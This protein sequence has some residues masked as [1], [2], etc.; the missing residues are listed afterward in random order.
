MRNREAVAFALAPHAGKVLTQDIARDIIATLFPD[1]HLPIER[2]EPGHGGKCVIRGELLRP[3]TEMDCLHDAYQQETDGAMELHYDYDR[4]LEIQHDGGFAQFTARIAET[5]EL[6]GVMRVFVGKNERTGHIFC[7]DN[8][9]FI[10]P[11]H[12]GIELSTRLWRYAERCMFD[13]GVRE[14]TFLSR[15]VNGADRMAKFLGYVPS[16]VQFSKVHV[17]DDYAAVTSRHT[18][19]AKP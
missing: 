11:K 19:G 13:L 15:H 1:R 12:R 14:V 7:R 6:A 18:E 8:L 16:A 17:G 3:T 4:M 5:G 9:F 2:F 10:Y